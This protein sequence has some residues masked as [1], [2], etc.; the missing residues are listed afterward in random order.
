MY[1]CVRM[2]TPI[3]KLIPGQ[4]IGLMVRAMPLAKML[5]RCKRTINVSVTQLT[6]NTIGNLFG[7]KRTTNVSVTQQKAELDKWIRGVS[8]L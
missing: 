2:D 8:A 7:C 3:H 5:F 6:S 1:G 4:L